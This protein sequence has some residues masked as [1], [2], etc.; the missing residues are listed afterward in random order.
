MDDLCIR[1][2]LFVMNLSA[3]AIS[4]SVLTVGIVRNDY[5]LIQGGS[6]T[7]ATSIISTVAFLIWV[8]RTTPRGVPQSSELTPSEPRE[9]ADSLGESG[10][11][12]SSTTKA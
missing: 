7:L 8:Y 12:R 9:R 2:V 11:S 10:A 4:T 3:I 1:D 5:Y 6:V